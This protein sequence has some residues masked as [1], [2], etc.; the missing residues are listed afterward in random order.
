MVNDYSNLTD[1]VSDENLTRVIEEE[2]QKLAIQQ[3]TPP[4]VEQ[5]PNVPAPRFSSTINIPKPPVIR[6]PVITSNNDGAGSVAGGTT[7]KAKLSKSRA[8]KKKGSVSPTMSSGWETIAT[9]I[10]GLI[11]FPSNSVLH[12][13]IE[14]QTVLI[15]DPQYKAYSWNVPLHDFPKT[16]GVA[17]SEI[18]KV[19]DND[20]AA[21]QGMG[22]VLEPLLWLIGSNAYG[23]VPAPWLKK[24]ERYKLV[25]W[26]NLTDFDLS[27]DQIYLTSVLGNTP[28]S[29]DELVL[30]S[31]A[32][33][34]EV[35]NTINALSLMGILSTHP[36]QGSAGGVHFKQRRN[37][38]FAKL[39]AKIGW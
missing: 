36:Y 9:N 12:V 32:S 4:N 37:G 15:I 26:P 20:P 5:S 28:A 31:G 35:V 8:G 38:L 23:G 10:K 7:Q 1:W 30:S 17:S 33:E 24:N 21:L 16:I 14:G 2:V 39:K 27:L 6:P 11:E 29:I 34:S 25:R 19:G 3:E 13:A 18:I 22:N